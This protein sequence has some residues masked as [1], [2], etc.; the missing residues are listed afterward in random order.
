MSSKQSEQPTSGF[1]KRF[2]D[3]EWAKSLAS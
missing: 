1:E 2:G 3:E